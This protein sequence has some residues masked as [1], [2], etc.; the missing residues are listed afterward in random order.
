MLSTLFDT[1]LEMLLAR[2]QESVRWFWLTHSTY[3]VNSC[4]SYFQTLPAGELEIRTNSIYK[5]DGRFKRMMVGFLFEKNGKNGARPIAMFD[6]PYNNSLL[7]EMAD[8]PIQGVG[9]DD[10]NPN[11]DNHDVFIADATGLT[12]DDFY[13]LAKPETKINEA[14]T[15]SD[16]VLAQAL[17]R[18]VRYGNIKMVDNVI[19]LRIDGNSGPRYLNVYLPA[20]Y[21][22]DHYPRQFQVMLDYAGAV[23]FNCPPNDQNCFTFELNQTKSAGRV[24]MLLGDHGVG[25]GEVHN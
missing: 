20:N 19:G 3:E 24:F 1:N 25:V 2:V 16:K 14:P 5:N 17:A 6:K 13:H 8:Q 10:I 22:E 11:A 7:A 9:S 15:I 18:E 23:N 4:F 21:E 12:K